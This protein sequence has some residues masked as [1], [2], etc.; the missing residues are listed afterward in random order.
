MTQDEM[1]E[2]VRH[3]V[4]F[5]RIYNLGI[6]DAF[7]ECLHRDRVKHGYRIQGEILEAIK[8]RLNEY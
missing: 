6:F 5:S 7:T 8:E 2:F 4:N 3:V 1:D